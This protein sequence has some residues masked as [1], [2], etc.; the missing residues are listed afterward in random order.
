MTEHTDTA[1]HLQML[2]DMNAV[3]ETALMDQRSTLVNQAI[4]EIRN[5]EEFN[6]RLSGRLEEVESRHVA[7]V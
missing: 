6:Q 7:A 4:V 5:R 1:Q 2:G 3:A